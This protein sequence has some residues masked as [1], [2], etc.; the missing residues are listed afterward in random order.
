MRHTEGTS[1]TDV[2]HRRVLSCPGDTCVIQKVPVTQ[3]C[4]TEECCPAIVTLIR[5]TEVKSVFFFTFYSLK[6][7]TRNGQA[8]TATY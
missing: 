5:H 4:H 1:D 2:S 3:M 6:F 8:K 7:Q